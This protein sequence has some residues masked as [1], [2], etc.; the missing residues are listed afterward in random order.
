[1]TEITFHVNVVDKLDYACRFLRTTQKKS[2]KVLVCASPDVLQQISSRL[3]AY[4][5]AEFLPHCFTDA[6]PAVLVL[7]TLV[8]VTDLTDT[9]FEHDVLLHL[10]A[11]VPAGFERFA[12]LIE[13]VSQAD[14]D[15]QP[16]RLRWSHYKKRGYAMKRYDAVSK[17]TSEH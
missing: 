14:V 5:P 6:A 2:A 16:A 17:E 7:S 15:V 11:G 13:V 4:A 9:R 3:W 1:M 12:R 10:G 8:L